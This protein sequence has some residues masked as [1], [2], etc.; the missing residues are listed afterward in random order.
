MRQLLTITSLVALFMYAG[1]VSLQGIALPVADIPPRPVL[2]AQGLAP[3]GRSLEAAGAGLTEARVT[4]WVRAEGADAKER[5]RTRLSQA[6]VI[7]G[8]TRVEAHTHEGGH[9]VS[10]S[11]HMT[12]QAA[13]QWPDAF[14][15]IARALEAAGSVPTVSV[16]VAGQTAR[17]DLRA[18]VTGALDAL[19]A[20]QRQPWSDP[21]AASSAAL[22]PYLP[23][24]ALGV[25]VQVAARHDPKAGITRVW[26]GWPA[27]NQEY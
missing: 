9:F 14:D 2:T 18:L 8:Q 4:G 3:L 10:A 19:G 27:L 24:S 22:S 16:Q 6:L 1:F 7:A 25:N 13:L 12:G 26:I 20:T 17:G 21:R 5:V 11:W 23:P 15:A